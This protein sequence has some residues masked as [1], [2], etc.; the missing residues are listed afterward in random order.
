MSA[1]GADA[2]RGVA[3]AH[4]LVGFLCGHLGVA[5]YSSFLGE[6]VARRPDVCGGAGPLLA[7]ALLREG[8][9][10]EVAL[11]A[12]QVADAPTAAGLAGRLL[13]ALDLPALAADAGRVPGG[14]VEPLLRTVAVLAPAA[15]PA[16]DAGA[17]AALAGAH[18]GLVTAPTPAALSVLEI[19]RAGASAPGGLSPA[20]LRAALGLFFDPAVQASVHRHAV[21]DLVGAL[22]AAAPDATLDALAA[23]GVPAAVARAAAEAVPSAPAP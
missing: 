20:L 14:A 22:L 5:A 3:D 8:D 12:P 11:L 9:A 17:L 13:D 23:A 1:P 6:L 18:A 7:D 2:Q 4:G 15:R 10:A 16:P 21:L 19:A